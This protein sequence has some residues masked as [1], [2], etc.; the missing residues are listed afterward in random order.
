MFGLKKA[1]PVNPVV[2]MSFI[3]VLIGTQKN[4]LNL[5]TLTGGATVV[6]RLVRIMK[7]KSRL[8]TK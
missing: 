3:V 2:G 5:N 4:F 6:T 1:F 7:E 8:R